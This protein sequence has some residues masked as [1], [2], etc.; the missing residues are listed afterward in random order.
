MKAGLRTFIAAGLLVAAAD[1]AFAQASADD[2]IAKVR[3]QLEQIKAKQQAPA[4]RQTAPAAEPKTK[5]KVKRKPV[6]QIEATKTPVEPANESTTATAA[7]PAP[8]QHGSAV[9]P[10]EP[11]ASAEAPKLD[12]E[13]ASAIEL[14]LVYRYEVAQIFAGV[15]GRPKPDSLGMGDVR[16]VVDWEKLAGMP[17]ITTAVDVLGT[18]GGDPSAKVGDEQGTSNVEAPVNTFKLYELWVQKS[19][20]SDKASL[21]VG[22]HDLNSEFYVTDA[23]GVFRNASFGVGR[24]F[25][26]TGAN[27]PSIYPE[28]AP[29]ARIKLSTDGMT[30][31]LGA[32]AAIAGDT[33][34]PHGTHFKSKPEDGILVI[35]EASAAAEHLKSKFAVGLWGFSQTREYDAP[36]R[37]SDSGAYVL[38]ER[39]I[40]GGVVAFVRYGHAESTN[41]SVEACFTTGVTWTGP[42]PSREDDRLGVGMTSA[43]AR[44]QK[45]EDGETAYE[46]TY[47]VEVVKGVA[48]QPDFQRVVRPGGDSEAKPVDVGALRLE[49][50]L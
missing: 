32:F 16:A 6:I 28:T 48:V 11:T 30:M 47:R 20:L 15:E 22:L 41:Q 40:V 26:Q 39:A 43:K 31:L 7:A 3:A 45:M 49:L 42:V 9:Q 27:G 35:S 17:G 2:T 34:K 36:G 24:E 12:N 4:A 23:A 50:S 44:D 19:G 5:T 1:P 21:L 8:T 18:H 37:A 14:S 46:V 29:S 13:D 38:A 10:S 33:E 25:S